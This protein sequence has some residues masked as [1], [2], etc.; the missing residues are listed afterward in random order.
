[1][2]IMVDRETVVS[3]IN[4]FISQQTFE[5]AVILLE[6]LCELKQVSK[7]ETVMAV[8]E[9]HTTFTIIIPFILEELER[10]LKIHRITKNNTLITVF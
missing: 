6:Y 3:A 4:K 7:D 10:T 8:T 1:M 2:S 9:N 5:N